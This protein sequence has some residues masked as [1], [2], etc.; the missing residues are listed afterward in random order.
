MLYRQTY[1]AD[2]RT[3]LDSGSTTFDLNVTDPITMLWLKFQLV[4]GATDNID[5]TLAPCI[6]AIEI[7]DGADVLWSLT[8]AKAMA[9]ACQ[10]M[11]TVPRQEIS[12]LG[13]FVVSFTVPILF[14]LYYGDTV[15]SFD[16]ARFKN[17]QVR[18]S[19]NLSTI[20]AVALTAFA[21]G[22]LQVSIVAHVMEGAPAPS[23]FLMTKE[24]YSWT[25][26]AAGTEFIDLPTDYP[27]R[28]LL[29]RGVLGGNPWHWQWD[30]IRLNGDGGKYIAMNVRG[31]DLINQISAFS[32]RLHYSHQYRVSN[33]RLIYTMLGE[34][35]QVALTPYGTADMVLEYSPTGAGR[36]TIMAV[37]G[38][39]AQA[40]RVN[41]TA[42][43]S[44]YNPYDVLYLPFG[45]QD[46][47]GDWF[48]APS[49]KGVKLEVRGG[50]A[51]SLMS[52]ALMQDRSY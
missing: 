2:N 13:G 33:G 29:C 9:L 26:V 51:A 32:P 25:S 28:G 39:V 5:N 16:P 50:V 17:P 1:L 8:G 27:W 10:Q 18:I 7:I 24:I 12:E 11:R 34:M 42:L 36:G 35:E 22:T 41:A 47:P 19:W 44:G 43:V 20:R 52:V 4:N 6:S 3:L 37:T 15:R 38:G 30:Q 23:G 40:A 46:L 21:T 31:W 14:G 45:R 48:P 49:F